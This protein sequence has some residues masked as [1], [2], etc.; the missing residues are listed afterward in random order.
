MVNPPG[1]PLYRNPAMYDPGIGT[2]HNS[3]NHTTAVEQEVV[4]QPAL[5]PENTYDA[6]R[7]IEGLNG[8]PETRPEKA[9]EP[10]D[11]KKEAELKGE[12]RDFVVEDGQFFVRVY[13]NTG[14][15]LRKIPP[16][17]VPLNEQRLNLSI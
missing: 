11:L 9:R 3:P 16:G 5:R 1:A 6:Q 13:S 17:F 8:K 7:N 15:L 10:S 2:I 4:A 12:K 14:K